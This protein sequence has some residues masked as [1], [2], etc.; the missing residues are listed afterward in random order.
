VPIGESR[1]GGGG[2]VEEQVNNNKEMISKF[3]I[4]E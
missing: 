3:A 2:V 4:G 1:A